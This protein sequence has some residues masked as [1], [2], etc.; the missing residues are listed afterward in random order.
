VLARQPGL[1]LHAPE[2]LRLRLKGLQV[3]LQAGAGEARAAAAREPGLLAFRPAE[4]RA[5]LDALTER[6]KARRRRAGALAGSV[7]ARAAGAGPSP[8]QIAARLHGFCFRP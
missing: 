3:L 5:R 7:R 4:L 2:T 1:L 6:L 8:L